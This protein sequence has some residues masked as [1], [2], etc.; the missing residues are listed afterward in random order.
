MPIHPTAVIDPQ[1]QIDPSATIDPYVVID[2]PVK[3]GPDVHIF[4]QV[5]ITGWTE[6]GA[7]YVGIFQS[8]IVTCQMHGIDPYTYLVDVLQRIAKHPA[9]DVKLLIPRLWKIHFAANPM[10]SDLDL[11]PLDR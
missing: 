7:K 6:I 9:K 8:L 2:G 10:R 4:P 11:I 5:Y 3:I 1:A